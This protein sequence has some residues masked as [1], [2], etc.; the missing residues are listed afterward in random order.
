MVRYDHFHETKKLEK[1]RIKSKTKD[2]GVCKSNTHD[3][4]D[5]VHRGI[6]SNNFFTHS[7]RIIKIYTLDGKNHSS[8]QLARS[9]H[10]EMQEVHM[11]LQQNNLLK[12]ANSRKFLRS[13][14]DFLVIFY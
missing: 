10:I 12:N 1:T 7:K 4:G 2:K 11:L 13:G 9:Y 8:N 5:T 3:K 6:V 14:V